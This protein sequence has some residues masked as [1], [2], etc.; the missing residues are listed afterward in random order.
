M[1]TNEEG[2][3]FKKEETRT[4]KVTGIAIPVLVVIIFLLLYF[5][6][7]AVLSRPKAG[8]PGPFAG[9]EA[10]DLSGYDSMAELL[11]VSNP[12]NL[13]TKSMMVDTTV[14]EIVEMMK[15]K[16]TF[17]L[18]ASFENCP[19]C[20][21]LI[22]YLNDALAKRG[23]YAGYLDTRKNPEWQN[24]ME[25]DDY[26][27]FVRYFGEFLSLD[28]EG[29]KHLYTPDLYFVRNGRVVA[30]HQGVIEGADD[31][32]LPLTSEQEKMLYDLLDECF[33]QL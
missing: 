11:Y 10:V 23:V 24:N 7:N 9:R 25:I 18:F 26:D 1:N 2:R 14:A 29:K 22:P 31:P 15:D 16:K 27:L 33:G 5:L 4:K 8:D 3:R 20:N 6:I 19:Y 21:R 13:N 28:A 17:V 30:H 32:D 12:G